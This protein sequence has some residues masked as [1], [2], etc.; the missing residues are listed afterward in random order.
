MIMTDE[1]DQMIDQHGTDDA[2]NQGFLDGVKSL[3]RDVD[4]LITDYSDSER[5]TIALMPFA[6]TFDQVL[7]EKYNIAL[8]WD[9]DD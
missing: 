3:A 5:D 8:V 2:Y 7:Q 4:A 9:S 1:L 6:A